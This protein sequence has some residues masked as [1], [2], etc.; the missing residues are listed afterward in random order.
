MWDWLTGV[1]VQKNIDYAAAGIDKA[2][3]TEEEKKDWEMKM[4]T[5]K[6]EAAKGQSIPRRILASVTVG[7]WAILILSGVIAKAWSGDEF[8]TYCFDVLKDTVQQ[9]HSIILGFYFL[10]E[11]VKGVFDKQ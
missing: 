7:V 8:A 1:D 2:F 3:W 10:K 4:A 9:P 11:V 6:V 5:L